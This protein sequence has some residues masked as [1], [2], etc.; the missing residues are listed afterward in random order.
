M[1]QKGHHGSMS[2]DADFIHVMGNTVTDPANTSTR[3]SMKY[4]KSDLNKT[5]WAK[6]PSPLILNYL[7][8][9]KII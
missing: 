2:I 7:L 4:F 8:L 3:E 9:I 6:R 5:E 1:T